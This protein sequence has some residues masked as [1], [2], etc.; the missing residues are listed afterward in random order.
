MKV[1]I[2]TSGFGGHI[3]LEEN[4]NKFLSEIDENR[5][6]NIIMPTFSEVNKMGQLLATVVYRDEPNWHLD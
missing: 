5:V 1:K 2:F 4:I 6:V 3:T